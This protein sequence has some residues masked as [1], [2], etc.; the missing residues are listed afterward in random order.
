MGN[1]RIGPWLV[2]WVLLGCNKYK[3]LNG[4]IKARPG[5]RWE[6]A[7]NIKNVSPW[8]A[9]TLSAKRRGEICWHHNSMLCCLYQWLLMLF[10]VRIVALPNL[11]VP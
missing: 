1:A 11:L 6:G 7:I 9:L 4:I 2:L 8:S 10:L 5:G 3:H